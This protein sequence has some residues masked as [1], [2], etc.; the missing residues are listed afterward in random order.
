MRPVEVENCQSRGR[1]FKPRRARHKNNR[2]EGAA[3]RRSF[4][5][6]FKD[7][8]SDTER[9]YRIYLVTNRY[10]VADLNKL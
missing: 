9:V 2:L 4:Y 10:V 6:E 5:G 8:L 3:R 7:G 1:G